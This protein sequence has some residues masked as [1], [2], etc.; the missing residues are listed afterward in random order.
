MRERTG[1]REGSCIPFTLAGR[2]IHFHK[3]R[4]RIQIHRGST[5]H[6]RVIPPNPELGL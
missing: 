4:S 2:H 1:K 6:L 5:L 3:A